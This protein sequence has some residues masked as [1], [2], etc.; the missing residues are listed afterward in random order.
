MKIGLRLFKL[1]SPSSPFA[2]FQLHIARLK[3]FNIVSFVSLFNIRYLDL[4]TIVS[5]LGLCLFTIF[6]HRCRRASSEVAQKDFQHHCLNQIVSMFE[7]CRN[8]LEDSGTNI[9]HL[10]A[11]ST[12]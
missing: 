1:I 10:K 6:N 7:I 5:T 4:K 12:V 8:Y 3:V 11:M 9:D 2:F